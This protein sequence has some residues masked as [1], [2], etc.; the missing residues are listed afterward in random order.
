M[1]FNKLSY[2]PEIDGL[3]AVAVMLIVLYHAQFILFGKDWF[4]GGF[5]GVD[6]F[7]VISGYLITRIILL[8]L[9]VKSSF[10]F[11]NFYERRARRIL[12][13]LFFVIIVSIPFAW[14]KLL[15]FDLVEYAQSI[16]SSIFFGSNFF[17]YFKTTAYGADELF[18]KPFLHTWS[19]SVE[20]Q[21]YLVFP[22]LT[23]LIFKFFKNHFFKI[24][25]VLFF[26]SFFFAEFMETRNSSLNFYLPFG[27]FWELAAGSILAYRE[28]NYKS[29]KDD[30]I[31][32][33]L[34][35][36]GLSLIIYSIFFLDIKTSH[37]S[38][39]KIISI[40]GTCLI[41]AFASKNELVGNL[42]SSKPFVWMGLISYS[43][44]LWHYPI[45]AFS[46]MGIE[47]NN[48]MKIKWI[49]IIIILSIT[50]FFLI[51]KPFRNKKL[52]S[53]KNFLITLL[54]SF[55][56]LL[57]FN[58]FS[59][60]NGLL[61]RYEKHL[62]EFLNPSFYELSNNFVWK[63]KKDLELKS[64][65]HTDN[66]NLT[67]VL[68]VGDSNSA[69]FINVLATS[70]IKNK[71]NIVSQTI[72]SRCF[73]F[74]ITEEELKIQLVKHKKK[75]N[76][77]KCK[78]QHDKVFIKNKLINDADIVFFAFNWREN[79]HNFLKKSNTKLVNQYG[80]KFFYVGT[81]GSENSQKQI[82]KL[83]KNNKDFLSIANGFFMTP[84]PK[85]KKI[86]N[87]FQKVLGDKFLD[88][89]EIICSEMGCPIY[90]KGFGIV[91]YD[92]FHLSKKGSERLGMS[93]EFN[94]L[95]DKVKLHQN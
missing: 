40:F 38:L 26:L 41:I 10:S 77:I 43:V 81:K 94:S 60:S 57:I 16:I 64:F 54:A 56:F 75:S 50:T 63:R 73:P 71:W 22:I 58:L 80:D 2:R 86:N 69:D 55:V 33:I 84:H 6:I 4:D 76:R 67:K 47:A 20:E 21:F 92:G 91:L 65:D 18:L 53:S 45:F 78:E 42:F 36:L 44:Y 9:I 1:I 25:F 66:K 51:E 11:S 14:K 49:L 52:I 61:I 93:L 3:R 8:E 74:F 15:P 82:A 28:L 5:I 59:M 34:P 31:K 46:R 37:A 29:S 12:P 23:I 27:R 30:K 72:I 62:A 90:E 68:I 87:E 17:F 13:M 85:R 95:I 89:N 7:F 39:S 35:M 32:K 88:W 79:W 83:L 70:N 19:L 48:F 24:I